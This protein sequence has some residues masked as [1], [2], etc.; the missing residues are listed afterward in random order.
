MFW[1]CGGTEI[2]DAGRISNCDSHINRH[3]NIFLNNASLILAAFI[4]NVRVVKIGPH[5]E[6]H[7]T[8]IKSLSVYQ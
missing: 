8:I 3:I 4:K 1:L 6:P 2:S 5:P 7:T